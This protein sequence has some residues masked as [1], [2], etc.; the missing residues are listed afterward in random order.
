M[1]IPTLDAIRAKTTDL[2]SEV[3]KTKGQI[4]DSYQSLLLCQHEDHKRQQ[5]LE[6]KTTELKRMQ[7]TL[8]TLNK[9]KLGSFRS[10]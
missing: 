1:Y 8:D 2:E 10:L 5:S 7:E 9:R 6:A 3:Y 4:N